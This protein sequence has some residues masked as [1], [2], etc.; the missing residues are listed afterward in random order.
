MEQQL[1]GSTLQP[2]VASKNLA[3][4]LQFRA[5]MIYVTK[6]EVVY[7]ADWD[8]RRILRCSPGESKP[9]VEGTLPAEMSSGF[10]RHFRYRK[11]KSLC[12][13]S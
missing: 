1:V 4:E 9:V 3:E 2:F 10:F 11:W 6:E 8:K 7:L 13:P 5:G 12:V